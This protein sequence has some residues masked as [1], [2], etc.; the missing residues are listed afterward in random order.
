MQLL[1]RNVPGA[2]LDRCDME[3]AVA[4][5]SSGEYDVVGGEA[6]EANVL[7]RF[8]PTTVETSA[9]LPIRTPASRSQ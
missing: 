2:D 3:P 7:K 9:P 5:A 6:S 1:P 4:G 8:S